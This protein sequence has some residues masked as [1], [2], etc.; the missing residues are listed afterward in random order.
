[1]SE[2]QVDLVVT[3]M[4]C[5]SCAQRIERKLNK[6]DGVEA[7]VNY[8]TGLARVDFA[9][10]ISVEQLISTVENAGY[11]ALAPNPL[12][13]EQVAQYEQEHED[14]L[15]KRWL[16]GAALAIPTAVI[17]MFPTLH[18]TQWQVCVLLL[19]LPIATW[20]AWPLHISSFK[21]ARHRAT[22]M[23]TLVSLGVTAAY[24]G[25]VYQYWSAAGHHEPHLYVE[26][27]GVVPVFVL[28]GRWLESRNKRL[29]GSSL[30]ALIDATPKSALVL[31]G[32]HFVEIA[33]SH[34]QIGDTVLI[35]PE[36]QIPV[37]CEVIEGISSVSAALLTGEATPFTVKPGDQLSAGSLNFEGE[38]R[39]RVSAI[40]SGTQIAR[41]AALVAA[42]QSGKANIA[43]L[44]DRISAIFVPIVLA[45]T[46]ATGVAWYFYSPSQVLD[47]MIAILVIACPCAL[48]LATPTA[49]VVGSG[50]AASLGILVSG[51][52]VFEQSQQLDVIVF[53][54]TGTLTQGE[55]SV[56]EMT[57]ASEDLP[58]LKSLVAASA[59]PLS[60]AVDR[61]LHNIAP[62]S[63]AAISTIAGLGVRGEI[64]GVIVEFGS[65][66]F[67][68]EI[69]LE[70][71][72][73]HSVLFKAG[74]P[75]GVVT[76]T[77]EI[78]PHA[79]ETITSLQQSG[80]SP[81][82][83]SGDNADSVA[84]VANALHISEFYGDLKPDEKIALVSRLQAADKKVIMVGDGTNDAPA[85]A[86][87]D[88]GI[89][90]GRGTEVARATADVTLLRP[91]LRLIP[92][93]ISLS[94]A[95]LKIIKQNLWWAFGYNVAAIPLAMTGHLN[96]M[97]AGIAM[98][99]SSVLVVTNS[100]RLRTIHL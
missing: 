69:N 11:H 46:I 65:R 23:D 38:L 70:V 82:V 91:D 14:D 42:A 95:T 40:G 96:P 88:L 43:R 94:R 32:D 21:N 25:S 68:P 12:L 6:L 28:I 18:F 89:A 93:T 5:A 85:L 27:A 59:H 45:I 13:D 33:S 17:S 35:R 60:R 52:Q 71:S 24:L 9:S 92:Q 50:R 41:I 75:A 3:G 97:I 77:D 81:I 58:L 83:A 22:T 87:A 84:A 98:S 63:V 49:L 66:R 62:A 30:R 34:I 48:G 61:H 44:A 39:A 73:T 100:L 99:V 79:E 20:V 80:I 2:Q 72:G 86:A 74:I 76:F 90:I 26:V 31:R 53:D 19:S 15:K 64:D 8:A 54:K 56:D 4:T 36:T 67:H 37:D 10:A 51:P 47:V 55:I 57:V 7:K 16:V 78:D 29:A 1:M